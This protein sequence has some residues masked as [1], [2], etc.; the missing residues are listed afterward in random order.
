MSA[1]SGFHCPAQVVTTCTADRRRVPGADQPFLTLTPGSLELS[2]RPKLLNQLWRISPLAL[3]PSDNV[4][5][6]PVRTR[7]WTR[8]VGIRGRA[9]R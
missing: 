6:F 9:R 2:L 8:G 3:C 4:E 7:G 1:G 5:A